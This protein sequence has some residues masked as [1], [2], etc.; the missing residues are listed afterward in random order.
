MGEIFASHKKLASGDV[1]T[2]DWVPNQGTVISVKGQA[3]GEPFKEPEFFNALLSIWLGKSPAD[4]LL[5]TALLGGK[6]G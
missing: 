3:Q 2:I 4:H 1:F 5:K 6:K